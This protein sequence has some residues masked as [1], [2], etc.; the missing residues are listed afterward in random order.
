MDHAY[1]LSWALM[2][3]DCGTMRGTNCTGGIV[4]LRN[5]RFRTHQAAFAADIHNDGWGWAVGSPLYDLRL[6]VDQQNLFGPELRNELV[7]RI[8]RQLL[9]AFMID[10]LP[11]ENN[12]VSVDPRYQD[13]LGNMRPVISYTPP[14]YTMRGAAY[15]RQLARLVF[16]RLGAADYTAYDTEDYGYITYEGEGYIIR[17]GNH[18]AGTHIMGSS[19]DRSVVD[20][21]QR[22]WE[23]ENLYLVG[24]GSMPTIGTSNISLTIAALCYKSA[25]A[26]LKVI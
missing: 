14:E 20:E 2:P 11:D 23:H 6:V 25:E 3:Q 26:I 1:L 19:A 24:G 9:L 21:D 13:D 16:Q 10:V 7:R 5:G 18:L 8:N 12:R 22:S 4:T 15:A 17:G